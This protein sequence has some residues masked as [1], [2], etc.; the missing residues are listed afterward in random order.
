MRNNR[1][2]PAG[3]P[4][5]K[6]D[7]AASLKQIIAKAARI[8]SEPWK[9]KNAQIAKLGKLV[10]EAYQELGIK[11]TPAIKDTGQDPVLTWDA[12]RIAHGI[13]YATTEAHALLR[14][15]IANTL[16]R[17]QKAINIE[18]WQD[19][20][21]RE[22]ALMMLRY[23]LSGN[24][25]PASE[26]AKARLARALSEN[27][28]KSIIVRPKHDPK[29]KYQMQLTA[30]QV[31]VKVV[32]DAISISQDHIRITSTLPTIMLERMMQDD[33]DLRDHIDL[34]FF[35][36]QTLSCMTIRHEQGQGFSVE[37]PTLTL[38]AL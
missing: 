7:N 11:V 20:H 5:H 8:G 38:N 6:S 15:D 14:E 37:S 26:H 18:Q 36:R 9:D 35:D 25:R 16:K 23:M 31:L 29:T 33:Y 10:K 17:E 19:I 2:A 21:I 3:R 24:I 27:E 34:A 12:P 4:E 32:S 30:K 28:G 1:R 13:R 22:H